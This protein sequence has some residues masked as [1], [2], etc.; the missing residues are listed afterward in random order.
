MEI[1]F[2]H[3]TS[4]TWTFTLTEVVVGAAVFS[5]RHPNI[6]YVVTY[7]GVTIFDYARVV[8]ILKK[9]LKVN[10]QVLTVM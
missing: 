3:L 6:N 8:N 2:S 7:F 10:F 1:L 9:V 5:S 4:L